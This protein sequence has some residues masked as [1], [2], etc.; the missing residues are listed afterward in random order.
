[1]LVHI[2]QSKIDLRFRTVLSSSK[3]AM[4][5]GL[6]S[7]RRAY[8]SVILLA[9]LSACAFHTLLQR[10]FAPCAP[11][12]SRSTHH[13]S[14][15]QTLRQMCQVGVRIYYKTRTVL[16]DVDARSTKQITRTHGAVLCARTP[17]YIHNKS[18]HRSYENRLTCSK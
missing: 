10:H 13:L 15:Q 12:L 5:I 17:F 7:H 1:M 9:S 18:L 3:K 4:S 6:R 11:V 2:R 14:Q 8:R 16:P